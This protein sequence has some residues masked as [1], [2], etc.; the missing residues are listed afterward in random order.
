MDDGQKK[1]WMC[2]IIVV[3]AAA[4]IGVL[5]YFSAPAEQ[6]DGGFLIRA[7]H[8]QYEEADNGI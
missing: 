3:L 6:S 7:A 5:Y 2:L 4:A 1:I 8:E